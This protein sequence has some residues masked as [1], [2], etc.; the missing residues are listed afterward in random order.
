LAI[1]LSAR[2]WSCCSFSSHAL[3]F[4]FFINAVQEDGSFGALSQFASSLKSH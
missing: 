1:G 4:I 2:C 3:S